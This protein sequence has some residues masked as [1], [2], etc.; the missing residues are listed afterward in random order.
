MLFDVMDSIRGAGFGSVNVDLIYGLPYQTLDT[1]RNTINKT[2]KLNPDRIAVF[3][4]AY[5]PWL[6]P[7]QKNLPQ[8][9]LPSTSEKL[10]I[11]QMT[12]EELTNN[13]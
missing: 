7:V 13:G 11:F 8:Q 1:F 5:V 12:I 4:F 9:A 10:A 6:K 3:N 2:I